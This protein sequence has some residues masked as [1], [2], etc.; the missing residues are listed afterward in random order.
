MY[1]LDKVNRSQVW[2]SIMS[3]L[4]G[5]RYHRIERRRSCPSSSEVTFISIS[6]WF[7]FTFL[8]LGQLMYLFSDRLRC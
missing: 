5:Y 1:D 6:C 7:T 3:K 4:L 8:F 2:L